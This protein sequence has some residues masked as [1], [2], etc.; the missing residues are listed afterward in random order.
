[1]T[2]REFEE[3][4]ASILESFG[5]QVSLTL[6]T[7]DGGYDILA[8]QTEAPGLEVS[9]IIECKHY[10]QEHR[11]GVEIVRGLYGVRDY[12]SIANAAVVTSSYF[13][14]GALEFAKDRKA[15]KLIDRSQL[16][17]W[18]SKAVAAPPLV[19]PPPR[20]QSVFISYS[21]EDDGFARR[22]HKRLKEAGVRAW[23]APEDLKAGEKLYEQLSEA[24]KIHDRLLVVLSEHSIQSEWVMTEIRKAR[25]TEKKEKRRK[26]FPIRLTDFETLRDWSCF[27][28]DTGKDLAVELREYF[29]PDF[30]NWKDHDAFEAAFARLQKDLKEESKPHN[31]T[32]DEN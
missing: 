25:E 30:S 27:D 18:I 31:K 8:I 9:W 19:S 14:K 20:F 32:T 21:T 15:I 24:V 11:V 23:F 16:L 28:A 7:R 17:A 2:G 10:A 29:I 3:L 26:L 4:V 1:L 12:L 6:P 22:L 13:T 5:W